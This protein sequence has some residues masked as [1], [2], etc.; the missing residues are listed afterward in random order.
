MRT[1]RR[2]PAACAGLI[3]L[4]LAAV[5]LTLTHHEPRAP[6][7]AH[8]AIADA[9]GSPSVRQALAGVHWSTAN[10]SGLDGSHERVSFSA[11]GRMLVDVLVRSNGTVQNV[12]AFTHGGVPYGDWIA[13]EPVVLALLSALF[14]LMVGVSPLRRM[15]NLDVLACLSLLAPVVLL[16]YRYVSASAIA[17]AP[18]ICCLIA[19]CAWFALGP[20]RRPGPST[21]LLQR[22]TPRW[23]P[24]QRVRTLRLALLMLV[25]VYFMVAVS[26][27]SADDVAYAVMEGATK[28][29][30]G[31]LPY[32]HLPGDVFH[33]D[34]YPIL[35]YAL[36]VPLAW[37]SPVNS[38]WSSVDV[39]L[40]A[41]VLAAV[42]SA[43]MLRRS[44]ARASGAELAGLRAALALLCFPPLLITASTGT[45][46]AALGAMVLAAV[47]LWQAPAAATGAL[48]LGGWFKLAPFALLPV[49]LAPRRGRELA[50]ALAGFAAVS[51]ASI[52][53]VLALGGPAGIS[54]MVH[55]IG[56]QFD[57]LSPQ[58]AWYALGITGL[59]PLGEAVVLAILAAGTV[60]AWRE[61]ERAGDRL[62]LSALSAAILLGLQFTSSQWAFM[63]LAWAMPLLGVS[64]FADPLPAVAAEPALATPPSLSEPALAVR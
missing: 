24:A 47:L 10:A 1:L 42:L 55:A 53:L 58:S 18:G 44:V 48:A 35:S 33:G 56:Y 31:V 23:D 40:G 54:A 25:L 20:R 64:L 50:A 59:Q 46:D 17:A 36:Y 41:A 19:R 52:G 3:V 16:Q 45:T 34:T 9:L 39:A 2:W 61:P 57:R 6:M 29:L 32:G 28:I 38:V 51:A 27:P 63:Y 26:S 15:R 12:G 62:R 4:V 8:T 21:P 43:W 60:H 30:H 37:V 11:G 49:W 5:A 14:F 22:L 13:Y 7:S